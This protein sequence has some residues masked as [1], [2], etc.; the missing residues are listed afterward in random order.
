MAE[1]MEVMAAHNEACKAIRN[2]I[3]GWEYRMHLI[4]YGIYDAFEGFGAANLNPNPN[5]NS[6]Q[7]GS[8]ALLFS[9]QSGSLALLFSWCWRHGIPKLPKRLLLLVLATCHTEAPC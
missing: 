1:K 2:E 8:L 4:K 9:W 6:W 7:S 5:P 3:T